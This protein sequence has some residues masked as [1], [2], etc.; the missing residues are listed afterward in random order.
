MMPTDLLQKFDKLQLDCFE[1]IEM[2]QQ[3]ALFIRSVM[4]NNMQLQSDK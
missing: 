3:C 4:I 1:S 2:Y